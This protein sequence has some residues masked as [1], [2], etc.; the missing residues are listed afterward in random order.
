MATLSLQCLAFPQNEASPEYASHNVW[1]S[2]DTQGAVA[3]SSDRSLSG[4]SAGSG[5]RAILQGFERWWWE[6]IHNADV[7]PEE[8]Q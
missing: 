6:E 8:G 2:E 4:L 7:A 1:I 5:L 3:I